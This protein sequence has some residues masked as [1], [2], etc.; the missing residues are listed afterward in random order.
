[1]SKN[2]GDNDD[3]DLQGY[4]EAVDL[5]ARVEFQSSHSHPPT[6]AP[7]PS[8]FPSLGWRSTVRGAGRR[9]RRRRQRQ[10]RR[11]SERLRFELERRPVSWRQSQDSTAWPSKGSEGKKDRKE[12]VLPPCEWSRAIG[13]HG[14]FCRPFS[15]QHPSSPW[16]TN[17]RGLG[18]RAESEKK[19]PRLEWNFGH[20]RLSSFARAH[21]NRHWLVSVVCLLV[22][23]VPEMGLERLAPPQWVVMRVPYFET[24]PL[25]HRR[26]RPEGWMD[27]W[28]AWPSSSAFPENG[29]DPLLTKSDMHLNGERL[30]YTPSL[31]FL[32]VSCFSNFGSPLTHEYSGQGE[33][34]R[35]IMCAL[36]GM[37]W[38]GPLLL[39]SFPLNHPRPIFWMLPNNH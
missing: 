35:P 6:K 21:R 39:A 28:D 29:E 26:R 1:M 15:P 2:D 38:L 34:V 30:S 31:W 5:Q 19:G 8:N 22:A 18:R 20:L 4:T 9:R 3:D 33:L 13:R 32:L 25:A 36:V 37:Q 11:E 16:S 14:W 10:A 27:G 17:Q 23:I 7:Q 12:N 24:H